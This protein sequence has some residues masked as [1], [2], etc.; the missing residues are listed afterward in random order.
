M[1]S[2]SYLLLLL[3]LII[4]VTGYA[5]A[6][7]VF[8]KQ[9]LIVLLS[10]AIAWA[11]SIIFVASLNPLP[12]ADSTPFA[13]SIA[14][15]LFAYALFRYRLFD[16]VPI[17]RSLLIEQMKDGV[18]VLDANNRI[19]DI[20]PAGK[21]WLPHAEIG[22]SLNQLHDQLPASLQQLSL[23]HDQRLEIALERTGCVLDLNVT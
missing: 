6:N 19:V 22:D 15:I 4:L 14:S 3:S 8:R 10:F 18:L 5:R 7:G 12:G 20:N 2:I 9:I 21:L 13:F 17:A 11:N 16:V 1:S 23:D